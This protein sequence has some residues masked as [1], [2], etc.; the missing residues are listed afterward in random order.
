MNFHLSENKLTLAPGDEVEIEAL[1]DSGDDFTI[2]WAANGDSATADL[3]SLDNKLVVKAKAAGEMK[4]LA[5][6]QGRSDLKA[7]CTL[8]VK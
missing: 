6:V 8:I 7:E 2:V 3:G 5:T 1:W 4:L